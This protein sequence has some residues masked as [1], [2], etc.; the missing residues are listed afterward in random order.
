MWSDYPTFTP[1]QNILSEIQCWFAS[2][3]IVR[4]LCYRDEF[5]LIDCSPEFND[6]FVELTTLFL[7]FSP[8]DV[9]QCCDK[10]LSFIRIF[11]KDLL[12]NVRAAGTAQR[13]SVLGQAIQSYSLIVAD[14]EDIG[15]NLTLEFIE[16]LL[17]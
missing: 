1:S 7:L 5:H 2:F 3:F 12:A 4:P 16:T 17:R 9:V 11:S 10:F 6:C 15:K 14:A 13:L 8:L